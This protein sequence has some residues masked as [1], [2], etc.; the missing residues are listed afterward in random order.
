[1]RYVP[2]PELG[3]N[4]GK[5]ISNTNENVK[6]EEP[7]IPSVESVEKPAELVV[8]EVTN[9]VVEKAVV[10]KVSVKEPLNTKIIPKKP[11]EFPDI[12]KRKSVTQ[13]PAEPVAVYVKG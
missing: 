5:V 13:E 4:V 3:A 2:N 10:T 11:M 7:L 6:L 9:P 1:M 12:F 8:E